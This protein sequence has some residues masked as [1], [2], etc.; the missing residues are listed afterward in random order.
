MIIALEGIDASG[1]ETQSRLLAEN[2]T[3]TGVSV[4]QLAFPRY[5]KTSFSALVASYLNGEFGTLAE[6]KPQFAALLFAGDRFESLS[7]IQALID[8]HEILIIDRYV[9]SNMA[10]QASRIPA[11]ELRQA[12]VEWLDHLEYAVYGLPRAAQTILL[13]VPVEHTAAMQLKKQKRVYTDKQSDIHEANLG[14]LVETRRVYVDLAE[15]NV[16]STW[17]TVDC[18]DD[19]G[20]LLSE[21]VIAETI[22]RLLSKP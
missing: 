10:H 16:G 14:Y 20:G 6:V 12:F 4:A 21:T 2:F 22:W 15:Q 17:H 13:D 19:S 3:A 8:Q 7:E 5:G 9:A 18:T 1:K 11:P